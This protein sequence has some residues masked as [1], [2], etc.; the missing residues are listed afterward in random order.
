M[1]QQTNYLERWFEQ[2]EPYIQSFTNLSCV[3]V[4]AVVFRGKYEQTSGFKIGP[5]LGINIECTTNL[6]DHCVKKCD[7]LDI[8][9]YEPIIWIKPL[10]LES[11]HDCLYKIKLITSRFKISSYKTDSFGVYGTPYVCYEYSPDIINGLINFPLDHGY[12]YGKY[13]NLC[14]NKHLAK[15]L[16]ISKNDYIDHFKKKSGFDNLYILSNAKIHSLTPY[17]ISYLDKNNDPDNYYDSD[18]GELGSSCYV[19]GIKV[20]YYTCSN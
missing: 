15:L 8:L 3:V 4:S 20:S 17:Q 16:T 2:F 1:S 10:D 6:F 11:H 5:V 9:W 19:N 14:E 18:D 7:E 13:L 12:K